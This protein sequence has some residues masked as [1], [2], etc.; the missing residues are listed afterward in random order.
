[1]PSLKI[2]LNDEGSNESD[3]DEVVVDSKSLKDIEGRSADDSDKPLLDSTESSNM[4]TWKQRLRPGSALKTR[5]IRRKRYEEDPLKSASPTRDLEKPLDRF[6]KHYLAISFISSTDMLPKRADVWTHHMQWAR[7]SALLPHSTA[8]VDWEYTRLSGDCTQPV[9]Q[10]LGFRANSSSTVFD[11]LDSEPLA[12]VGGVSAWQV[13][14]L[15]VERHENTTWDRRFQQMFLAFD[16]PKK[17]GSGTDSDSDSLSAEDRG[18]LRFQ[19]LD[20]H[21]AA[22]RRTT[23]FAHLLPLNDERVPSP[24]TKED[25]QSATSQD[26]QTAIGTLIMINARTNADAQRHFDN[27]PM[28]LAGVY[29]DMNVGPVNMQDI[30]GLHHVMA[31]TFSQKTQLDQIHFMDPE[32]L[33]LQEVSDIEKIP[34]HSSRN[35]AV[36]QTLKDEEISHRY[37]RLTW[38]ER[39]NDIPESEVKAWNK[40]MSMEQDIRLEPV[41]DTLLEE[42]ATET[43]AEDKNSDNEQEKDDKNAETED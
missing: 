38:S 2:N 8:L 10:V 32:D 30:D 26:V 14:E 6:T 35:Q 25:T 9:G 36:L 29:E 17:S 12:A 7:R 43:E 24:V 40:V 39:H 15:A 21:Q 31:R 11:L 28:V 5:P 34:D 42:N 23:Y 4:I 20:Y 1:M 37:T 13:Y 41:L 33:L 27:D 19:Q 16:K 18:R 3:K 22:D